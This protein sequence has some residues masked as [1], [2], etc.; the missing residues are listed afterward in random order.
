MGEVNVLVE[1][2]WLEGCDYC[3]DP[4]INAWWN[5]GF[6]NGFKRGR[7]LAP[8]ASGGSGTTTLLV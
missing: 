4:R 5:G 1:E 7:F 8:C 2:W 6:D 3:L